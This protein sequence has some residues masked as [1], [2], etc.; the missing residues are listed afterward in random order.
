[1]S[2]LALLDEG[3]MWCNDCDEWFSV[4]RNNTPWLNKISYCPFC[5]GDDVEWI[6]PEE[7]EASN[8]EDR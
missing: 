4:L 2:K 5:G 7:E 1:M 3:N 6:E 8:E